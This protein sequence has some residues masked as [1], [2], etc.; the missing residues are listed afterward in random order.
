MKSDQVDLRAKRDKIA[1]GNTGQFYVAGELCRRGYYAV[2]TLG[3]TPNTDILC[4]DR[5]GQRFVHVQVKTFVPGSKTCSIGKKAENSSGDNFFW[6]LAGIPEPASDKK[7]T[8]YIVP[9]NIIAEKAKEIHARWLKE[10][11]RNGTVHNPNDVRTLHIP[12][13]KCKY[14]GDW[15]LDEYFERWDL[16]AEKL[17]K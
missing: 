9:S 14:A 6:V 2:V 8:Y 3:N 13:F 12:P 16:I 5:S 11:G 17:D 10:P 1:R 7:F 15:T 4:S